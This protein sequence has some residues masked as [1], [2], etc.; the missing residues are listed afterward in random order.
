ME[1]ASIS[2]L[3]AASVIQKIGKNTAPATS[4]ASTVISSFRL[5][6]VFMAASRVQVARHG[7]HQ[8]ERYH[9]GEND[10]DHAARGGTAHVPFDQGA[11]V[12][13]VGERGRR[14]ARPARR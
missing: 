11:Q 2:V 6:L 12:D 7:A 14:I 4:H 10:C 8:E 9:I 3:N 13:E 5:C 1:T